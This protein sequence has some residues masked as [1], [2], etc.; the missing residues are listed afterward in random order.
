[1]R[2]FVVSVLLLVLMGF[3]PLS[4]ARSLKRGMRG[5]EIVALQKLFVDLGYEIKID[6]IF[7]A[8]T[9]KLVLGI[10][11]SLDLKVDGIVGQ[12]TLACLHQLKQSIVT[13]TVQT[14]DN[15]TWLAKRYQTTVTNITKYNDLTNPDQIIIGQVLHIPTDSRAVLSRSF[16]QRSRFHW[17]VQ[18]K[19]TS[20]YGYRTHPITK[21]R[22]FHGGLD[23]AVPVGTPVRA[24]QSGQVIK[25]GNMGNYGL[26]VVIDHGG[27][28]TTWYGHNSKILVKV[29]DWVQVGQVVTLSGRSGSATGPHLDF[30][31]KKGDQTLDPLEYL[32]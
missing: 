20:G 31:I 16:L 14:G 26:G 28:F 10:Q 19:I 24:S 32:F 17:P 12:E 1:M 6:G 29:G 3:T 30:R 4:E 2:R 25:A 5:D 13:Y 8:D 23:L 27:G 22:Q 7:G 15:L 18:G 9:E 21:I 11:E